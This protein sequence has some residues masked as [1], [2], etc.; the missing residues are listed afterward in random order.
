MSGNIFP[1][2][3]D[4]HVAVQVLL[5]WHLTGRLEAAEDVA[6]REHLAN[7]PECRTELV[8]ERRWLGLLEAVP[9]PAPSVDAGWARLQARLLA[10]AATPF[11]LDDD[12]DDL[13]VGLSTATPAPAPERDAPARERAPLAA[14][15]AGAVSA[16]R[17]PR[18]R[19]GLGGPRGGGRPAGPSAGASLGGAWRG[20]FG[21]TVGALPAAFG[22]ALVTLALVTA[23]IALF[24]LMMN[25]GAPDGAASGGAAFHALGAAAPGA[26]VAGVSATEGVALVRFRPEATEADI[27]HALQ[28]CG[29]RLVDGPTVTDAWVVRLPAADYAQTLASLRAQPAVALAEALETGTM[30]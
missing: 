23:A 7:C 29:A 1:F 22:G 9:A 11:A 28:H 20:S 6:V 21:R 2:E 4:P 13:P 15:S 27:R 14:P 5:P 3:P 19:I 17:P 24:A 30:R 8:V 10:P 12:D 26:V 18:R 25:R 16:H